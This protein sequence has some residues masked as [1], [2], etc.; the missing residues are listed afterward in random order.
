[1]FMYRE[2]DR[3][4]NELDRI[5]YEEIQR[6]RILSWNKSFELGY[7]RALEENELGADVDIID[8]LRKNDD[9]S[10]S[11]IIEFI[12]D[13]CGVDDI[14][15]NVDKYELLEHLYSEY[16]PEDFVCISWDY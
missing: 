9:W 14:L 1:M 16:S 10:V 6:T 8:W 15:N 7:E 12:K 3:I 13:S 2:L 11:D 4:C 5:I